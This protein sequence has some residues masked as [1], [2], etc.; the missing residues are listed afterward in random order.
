MA[1]FF[2]EIG[3]EQ[4]KISFRSQGKVDVALLAKR[5]GGG[6]HIYAAGC[7]LGGPWEKVKEG[8]LTSAQEA[9]Y[10]VVS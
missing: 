1:V 9:I 2:R 8:V 4:Y 6:G 3:P 5:W 7:T 10:A